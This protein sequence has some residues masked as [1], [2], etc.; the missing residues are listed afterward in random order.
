VVLVSEGARLLDQ[1]Q[2]T[3]EGRAEDQFGH[4]KLGGI[5]DLISARLQ[6]LSPQ[7]NNG[8]TIGVVNQRLG[9]LVRSGDPDGVDSIVGMAF[10][11]H[12]LDLVQAGRHGRLVALRKGCYDSVPLETVAATKKIVNVEQHYNADRLRP[13]YRAFE[14]LPMFIMGWSDG[15]R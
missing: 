3:F 1:D 14:G 8:K 6:Q 7:F 11:N 10:G 5:G 13:M 2:M 15:E 4:R 12:A 9:Y